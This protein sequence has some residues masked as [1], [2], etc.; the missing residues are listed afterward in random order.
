MLKKFYKATALCA[1]LVF[2]SSFN[3]AL[4]ESKSYSLDKAHTTVAFL[5]DHIGYA[6][7]LGLFTDV[8]GS[9]NFDETTGMVSDIAITVNTASVN[10]AN[11][12]RDKHVRNKDFLDVKNHPEMTFSAAS[13]TLDDQGN[14]EINGELTLLGTTLPL[15]LNATLNKAENYPFGHKRFTLGV[16]AT[17]ALQRS[18]YG[19]DYGVANALVGDQVDMI[20]EIEAIQDK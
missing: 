19:M 14:A 11:E 3:S 18:A 2:S 17:G 12:A 8:S 13:A 6:K 16:S 4:A 5:I 1:A 15:T 7:T 10:T 20:I 9:L